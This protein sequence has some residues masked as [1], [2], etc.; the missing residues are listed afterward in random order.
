MATGGSGC[1][2]TSQAGLW[3]RRGVKRL[4]IVSSLLA[5]VVSSPPGR[6]MQ[7]GGPGEFGTERYHSAGAIYRCI[8]AGGLRRW[9]WGRIRGGSK[10]KVNKHSKKELNQKIRA[11]T[12]NTGGGK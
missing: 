10:G 1:L 7:A 5:W 8:S 12:S 6:N 2:P 3:G 11:A 4:A 9:S